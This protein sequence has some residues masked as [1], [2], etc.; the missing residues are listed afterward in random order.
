MVAISFAAFHF[1]TG[2]GCSES[3][4]MTG[5]SEITGLSESQVTDEH[6]L[7]SAVR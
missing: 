5:V 1:F 6:V 7:R 3:G 2:L 4:N